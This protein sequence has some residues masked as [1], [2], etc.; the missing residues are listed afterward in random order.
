VEA[1][2]RIR[3]YILEAQIGSGG[4][5]VVWRARHQH[6]KTVVAIKAIYPHFACHPQFNARFLREAQTTA[7]LHHPHIVPV[8]DFFTLND[9]AYLVMA[10]IDGESL[11]SVLKNCQG[12]PLPLDEVLRT[13]QDILAA[14][15]FA[16]SNGVIHRDVKP[17]N[18]LLTPDGQAYLVDFGIALMRGQERFT[19][20]GLLVGTEKY[21]SPEQ[22]RG[23]EP[24]EKTDI[25]S[26]G[27]VLYEM[28]AGRPPFTG[29]A[30]GSTD[31]AM[32]QAHLHETPAPLRPLNPA[33]DE[34]IE[35]VV[36][37]ALAKEP[38][39][40][41]DRCQDMADALRLGPGDGYEK[42]ML[43]ER[44]DEKESRDDT[45]EG[46]IRRRQ[47]VV[48]IGVAL[49]VILLIIGAI[50]LLQA[51]VSVIQ[52]RS[53]R[54]EDDLNK[55]IQIIESQNQKIACANLEQIAL[56]SGE[57]MYTCAVAFYEQAKLE[58][59]NTK[60][61]QE[62]LGNALILWKEAWRKA[63]HGP[64]ALALGKIYDP[65]LW[66]TIPSP[67]KRCNPFQAQKWYRRA[68]DRNVEKA[69]EHLEDLENWKRDHTSDT[70]Q[71]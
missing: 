68:V 2:Q 17:S 52:E 5:G 60:S 16:H 15:D 32:M 50:W 7:A 25:Y 27:C 42:G 4:M 45:G 30:E 11:Q 49:G 31:H 26:F 28:L 35:S 56:G 40:R 29:T 1:G 38:G 54:I 23:E 18:I 36:M 20:V 24:D 19:Q 64:S 37:R 34:Q 6:L 71:Q 10:Y 67:F 21:M 3:D 58:P 8:L 43:E 12:R 46:V 69:L 39:K 59:L 65:V 13:A 57:Q 48:R 70:C 63:E 41:F 53:A 44:E 47:V 66:G 22:V 51:Y 62:L 33:I 9:N 14:L 61:A 55:E